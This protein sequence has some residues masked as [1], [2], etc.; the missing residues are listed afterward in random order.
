[1]AKFWIKKWP[2]ATTR[3]TSPFGYRIHPISG[4]KQ[5]HNGID[6]APVTKVGENIVAVANGKVVAVGFD[7]ARGNYVIVDHG[8][9]RRTLSQHLRSGVKVKNRQQ[10]KAGQVLGRM[11]TTGSSTAEHL[12]FSILY[13]GS[14]VDP[15]PE[16]KKI[17]TTVYTKATKIKA[18]QKLIGTEAD[19]SWGP[20]TDIK[21]NAF[22][23]KKANVKK[24]QTLLN[25]WEKPKLE[26]DGK[27]GP[28]TRAATKR[29]RGK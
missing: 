20:K 3:V 28:L 11:G 25:K 27:N 26:V 22:I 19:A 21:F 12:H 24:L 18:V 9:N 17:G 2:C 5:L 10:V 8:S 7:N 23:K 14:Y 4:K 15:L 6:L 1:M 16:L 29:V 13:N